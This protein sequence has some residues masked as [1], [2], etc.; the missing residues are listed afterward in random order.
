[1]IA[2]FMLIF[3]C[4]TALPP[5]DSLVA[6]IEAEANRRNCETITQIR[7]VVNTKIQCESA[8]TQTIGVLVTC[9][10]RKIASK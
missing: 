1:M 8:D 6:T 10:V 5:T 7:P 2:T 9:T 3:Q 4:V